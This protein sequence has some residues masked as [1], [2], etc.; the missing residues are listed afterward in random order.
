MVH[1]LIEEIE[2]TRKIN[3]GILNKTVLALFEKDIDLYENVIAISDNKRKITYGALNN[4]ANSLA[5]YL[6]KSGVSLNTIVA[7]YLEPSIEF[8]ISILAIVKVGAAYLPLD[9]ETPSVRVNTILQGSNPVKIITNSHLA[10]RLSSYTDC[11]VIL[12]HLVL[13]NV[14]LKERFSHVSSPDDLLY[15][16]YTSGST[17][18]PKGCM[19]PHRAVV[20]LVKNTAFNFLKKNEHIAHISN[21][22]F[23][24]STFEIWGGLLNRAT[25]YIFPRAK[26]VSIDI[27]A[28][29]LK[30]N[31]I[32]ILF[33]TTAFFN[34]IVRN[35]PDFF[36][37]LQY[38]L[39]G[40]EKC[41]SEIVSLLLN[42][43]KTND[44]N[45]LNIIHVYGP[46]E[47]TTFSTQ[48]I[49]ETNPYHE[50][51][52]PIGEPLENT[53]VY[54][55]NEMNEEVP[56]NIIGEICL[57]G[58]SLALGYFNDINQTKDK[59]I[60]YAPLDEIIY[61][62]GDFGYREENGLITLIGRRDSQ[63]KIRGHRIELCEIEKILS[64]YE[65]IDQVLIDVV[66]KKGELL[67]KA[68]IIPLPNATINNVDFY[69]FL[70][71][72]IPDY[73]VPKKVYL[74]D[75]FP[76]NRN[77]K[78]DKE[79]LR[80]MNLK[81]IFNNIQQPANK[82]EAII[83]T[84]FNELLNESNISTDYNFFDL[85]L[86]SL[87][88]VDACAQ[89]NL[90]INIKKKI[91]EIDFFTHPTIKLLAKYITEN[92]ENKEFEKCTHRA[93]LQRNILLNKNRSR[94]E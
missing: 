42:R 85:G 22:A 51:N 37:S 14:K 77:G 92:K 79:K 16:M 30:E 61:K 34:L 19:I 13:K 63:I 40:G 12:N 23:D 9:T 74:I 88:V 82:I 52:L 73:M 62:T 24:A 59:F 20:N 94:R 89:L 50:K 29:F 91:E 6:K 8:I 4:K 45:N 56:S 10:T 57:G 33:L 18:T 93:A 76:L 53:H 81:T 1:V 60:T 27:F 47:N 31:K 58:Q 39:F 84:L 35:K 83:A 64:K 3:T 5:Q 48:Y 49:L 90:R 36:D 75:K 86:D 7:V 26:L 2:R 25:L 11:T 28:A 15:I 21:V 87:M 65:L 32:S 67:I 17:G 66:T 44:L 38:L 43:K 54:I 68:Y 46:T 71:K 80:E 69:Y 72:N 41:N 70:H 55:L 78:I